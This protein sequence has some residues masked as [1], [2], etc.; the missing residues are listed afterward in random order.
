[1]IHLVIAKVQLQAR[2]FSKLAFSSVSVGTLE[3]E[4]QTKG[5]G[6][7]EPNSGLYA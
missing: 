4:F 1:M 2:M 5:V 7:L 6:A 3:I